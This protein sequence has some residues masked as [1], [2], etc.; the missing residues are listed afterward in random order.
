MTDQIYDSL[1]LNMKVIFHASMYCTLK[2]QMQKK[3]FLKPFSNKCP[4]KMPLLFKSVSCFQHT[5]KQNRL[6]YLVG[7]CTENAT[8]KR[9]TKIV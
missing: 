8:F 3:I 2:L 5:W 1:S 7:F 4:F 6:L 9:E